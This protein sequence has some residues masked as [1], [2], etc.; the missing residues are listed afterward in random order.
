MTNATERLSL[1]EKLNLIKSRARLQGFRR[2]SLEDAVQEVAL[3][4]LEF[5]YDAEKSNG[6][7]ETTALVTV[8]DRRLKRVT[9]KA[10]KTSLGRTIGP[11][12]AVLLRLRVAEVDQ[13]VSVRLASQ[14]TSLTY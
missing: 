5:E 8:I 9:L 3:V 11:G 4:V 10:K 2:H 7:T 6:A 12:G 14:G 1:I 13:S